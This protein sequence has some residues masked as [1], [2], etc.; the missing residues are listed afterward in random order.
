MSDSKLDAI[1]KLVAVNGFRVIPLHYPIPEGCSCGK[2]GCDRIGKHPYFKMHR[3]QHRA[4]R[5]PSVIREWFEN[6]KINVG[7]LTGVNANRICVLDLDER[8]KFKGSETLRELERLHSP[9]PT[10]L[11][12]TTG[13]G[14]HYYF[15]CPKGVRIS[16]KKLGLGLETKGDDSYVVAPP[17]I[18]RNGKQYAWEN[19]GTPIAVAPDWLISLVTEEDVSTPTYRIERATKIQ[20]GERHHTVWEE[21][22]RWCKEIVG[23]LTPRDKVNA[24]SFAFELNQKW[25]EPPID[26]AEV[27][28]IVNYVLVSHKPTIP[29][30]GKKK[31]RLGWFKISA[32]EILDEPRIQVLTDRQFRIRMILQARA[33]MAGGLLPRDAKA[34][35]LLARAR[36]KPR[37]LKDY[38]DTL[39][40]FK[41]WEKNND[42]L[43]NEEM[44][45]NYEK[46][47][48]AYAKASTG[49]KR[50][51]E[52]R[53]EIAFEKSQFAA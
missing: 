21:V 19:E 48:E 32:S 12:A 8:E 15:R 11:T 23:P 45:E 30:K 36:S 14:R 40:D 29:G 50:G 51:G 49:G 35:F 42:M 37:F 18:H 3:W 1:I 34:L 6:P 13:S 39:F 27:R 33:W 47:Q 43:I 10:T 9:L 41:V 17:S 53:Q 26:E 25:C 20:E 31:G 2:P 16:S 5:R 44:R 46:A 7:I 24:M 38:P 22:C 4:T 28:E 52:T